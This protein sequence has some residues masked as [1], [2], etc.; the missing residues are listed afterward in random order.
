MPRPMHRILLVTD[1]PFFREM[2]T[3]LFDGLDAEVHAAASVAEMVGAC[4]SVAFDVVV[5]LAAAGLLCGGD[6]VRAIRPAGLRRPAVYVVAWQQSEQ[7]VL[8]LLECGVD[9]YLTLPVSL[10]RLRRK[11]AEE[12]SKHL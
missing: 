3:F 2:L 5:L 6:A 9:Q 12:L 10:V 1:D 7:T 11:V 8:S 4:R